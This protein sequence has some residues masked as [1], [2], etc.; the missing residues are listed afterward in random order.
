MLAERAEAQEDSVF[1][2]A[3]P[4]AVSQGVLRRGAGGRGRSVAAVRIERMAAMVFVGLVQQKMEADRERAE[5]WGRWDFGGADDQL[6]V[7]VCVCV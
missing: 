6:C 3:Y 1:Q 2:V 5:G 4:T 7:C